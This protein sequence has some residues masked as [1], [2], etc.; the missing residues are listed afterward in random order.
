LGL[1]QVYHPSFP[2]QNQLSNQYFGR[3]STSSIAIMTRQQGKT[4]G[5]EGHVS[6]ALRIHHP[7]RCFVKPFLLSLTYFRAKGF[8]AHV[9]ASPGLALTR[10]PLRKEG[11]AAL[12]R[13]WSSHDSVMRSRYQRGNSLLS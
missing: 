2:H 10:S 13:G 11:P 7:I 1:H 6:S 9:W 12:L 5:S 8:L 3:L 4:G